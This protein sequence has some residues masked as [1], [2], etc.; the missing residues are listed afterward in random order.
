MIS[1]IVCFVFALS[2][3]AGS[4][5]ANKI[6]DADSFNT[7]NNP[8]NLQDS[9]DYLLHLAIASIHSYPSKAFLL[10]SKAKQ[11]SGQNRWGEKTAL[12]NKCMGE[13]KIKL[14]DY[15]EAKK[16]LADALEYYDKNTPA[17]TGE[18]YLLLG[19]T[20][21]FLAEY[22]EASL[23]FRSAIDLFEVT[24]DIESIA[25]SYQNIG[26]VHHSLK[27]L[28]KASQYY[29][30]ALE[31]NKEI[32]NDTNIAALYQNLGII[33]YQN[34]DYEK[35]LDYYSR[36]IHMYHEL[37]DTQNIAITFSNIGLI[38]LNQRDHV[39]AFKSFR[40]SKEYFDRIQYKLGQMWA[41]HNMGTAKLYLQEFRNAE[42]YYNTSLD[43]ARQLNNPEGIMSNLNALTELSE[44]TGD[45]ERAFQ[46][47]VDYTTL[48]DSIHSTESKEKIA[49][50]EAL[51]NLEA[52]EKQIIESN[53]QLKKQKTQKIALLIILFLLLVSLVIIYIAYLQKKASAIKIVSHKLDLENSLYAKTRE[54]ENEITERKIAE[55]SDKLKSSF[56]ANMSHE[57]RTPMNAI[58]AF[59]NFLKDPEL[60][61]ER[62]DEYLD[63][64]TNAGDNLLR[65]ID[66]IIDTAKIEAKQLKISINP[67]N[68]SHLLKELKRV[69]IKLKLKYNYPADLILNI[70]S[71]KDYII[72]TDAMR[73]RQ[74]MTNLLENAFKYTKKGLVEF[75]FTQSAKGI[76]FY[77]KDTGIG[78]REERLSSIFE[79]FSQIDSD[80]NR[81][82]GGTGLGLTISKN[83]AE[84]L[85]GKL[86]V[87]SKPGKG[88]TFT[89]L[90]PATG[91]RC[92]DVVNEKPYVSNPLLSKKYNWKTITILIAEDEELNFKVLKSCL[93]KTKATIIRA[94]DGA[95]AVELF[96]KEKVDIVLMDIQMPVMDGYH[97]VH[98][99]KKLNPKMPVIAQTSYVL[100]NEREKCLDAGCDDYVT[101]PLDL[102][103]LLSKIDACL[104]PKK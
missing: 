53:A 65:L 30:K 85:G 32:Q 36:S 46:Y 8:T 21:Y 96:K 7:G 10:A 103:N 93:V 58:I 3:C 27:D 17:I 77:V 98:E 50:L 64:I 48:R 75:G 38:Q 70:D 39:K 88:S 90:V 49:E 68:I 25:K 63:H 83:L 87:E 92:V 2:L 67:I 42:H 20:N 89:M 91:L 13:S 72:N 101:K 22:H 37:S 11:I 76:L 102:E 35:A 34:D 71:Q 26:L 16:Y 45:Y 19:K 66:D 94:S 15:Y 33:Y 28:E 78:I 74:V 5:S 24:E 62:K 14:E 97:A 41:L 4:V 23:N 57:L 54:L 69:F 61:S 51:Y 9:V 47:Y 43:E 18:I 55:E 60:T 31:I 59:A 95:E 56:L 44:Q 80:L 52:Q 12:A 104:N 1:R 40:K 84:L 81:K 79:R 6:S 73:I 100:A 82:Y 99:I 29:N 86:G